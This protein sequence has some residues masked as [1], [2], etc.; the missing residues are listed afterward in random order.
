VAQITAVR[1]MVGNN[2]QCNGAGS[3]ENVFAK[4]PG[5]VIM[6]LFL[7]ARDTFARESSPREGPISAGVAAQDCL[8]GCAGL[9]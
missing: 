9:C 1:Q 4:R 2:L 5:C 6:A 7:L 8:N 3:A